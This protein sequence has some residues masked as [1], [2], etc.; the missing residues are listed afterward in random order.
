MQWGG[1]QIDTFRYGKAFAGADGIQF[2]CPKCYAANGGAVGTHGLQ[3]F[4]VGSKVPDRIGKN[5]QG[6]TV[7]WGA[8]G[9]GYADLTLTPSI[10]LLGG[11]A[12]HGW[13]TRGDVISC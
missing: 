10:L 5:A 9:T 3:V 6:Q 13:I 2:L 8:S 11:C 12:W 1:F 4:F 7:R